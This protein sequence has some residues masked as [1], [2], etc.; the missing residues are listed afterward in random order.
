MGRRRLRASGWASNVPRVVGQRSPVE[1][2]YDAR[3]AKTFTPQR[4]WW[5]VPEGIWPCSVCGDYLEPGAMVH[6]SVI[7]GEALCRHP[8]CS[9]GGS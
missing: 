2:A 3:P 6:R 1:R 8:A 5:K 7:R 9:L 4:K